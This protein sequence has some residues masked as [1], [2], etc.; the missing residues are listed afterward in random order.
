MPLKTRQD[1][2]QLTIENN[3]TLLEDDAYFYLQYNQPESTDV[4]GLYGLRTDPSKHAVQPP[5]F[6][7]LDGGRHKNVIRLDTV[8]K[9]LCPGMYEALS[10]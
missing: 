2:Y 8:S 9:F 4:P 1:I 3:A 5:S 6:L 7:N 10:G